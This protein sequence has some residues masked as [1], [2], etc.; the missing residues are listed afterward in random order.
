MRADQVPTFSIRHSL[1]QTLCFLPRGQQL[2]QSMGEGGDAI[3]Q[4]PLRDFPQVDAKL[5]KAG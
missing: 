5:G 3:G 1:K 4:Q 2:V